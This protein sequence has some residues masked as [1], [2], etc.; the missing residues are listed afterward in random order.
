MERDIEEYLSY[1]QIEKNY[2]CDTLL[3]YE[4]DLSHFLSFLKTEAIDRFCL[5]SYAVVRLYLRTLYEKK[6]SKKT[7]TRHISTLRSFFRYLR[8]EEKIKENPMTLISN[9]KQDHLL[10]SYL[11]H[12]QLE[13]FLMLPDV[14]TPMGLRDAVLL[15]LIYA[16][17]LRVGELVSL[18]VSDITPQSHQIKIMGKGRKER[19]VLFGNR[20]E[21]LLERYL[22]EARPK[23]VLM[24]SHPYLLVNRR[25]NPLTTSGV[26]YA[27][28][29]LIKENHLSFHI[30]PHTL[31]HTF[32]TDLLNEGADLKVVQELL[33]H[34]NLKTTQIYTHVS[35]ER[36]KNV[37]L[38]HHPRAHKNKKEE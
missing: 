33:G 16:T 7:I 12:E 26:R 1:I 3:G 6:Y 19:Y 29:K 8:K 2:S 22:K 25:G 4:A 13:G 17:G 38:N 9:P 20:C 31:R 21:K 34:E 18:K 11:N 32:A 23:L 36:L 5:V 14:D 37:Y 30:T 24:L 28:S 27:I 15:E 35:N 10:P